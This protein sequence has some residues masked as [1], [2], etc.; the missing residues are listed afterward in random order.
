MRSLFLG[1]LTGLI[2]QTGA[3]QAEYSINVRGTDYPLAALMESC[4]N[5]N[6]GPEAQLR[7]FVA[8]TGLVKEQTAAPET[9]DLS[10]TEAL[11]GLRA[12]AEYQDDIS[13][14]SIS[15]TDCTI[16]VQYHG[17]YFYV[18]RRNVTSIDLLSATFDVSQMQHDQTA[19]SQG[20]AVQHARGI[21]QLGA[22]ASTRG[23]LA[24]ESAEHGFMSKTASASVSEYAS[25]IIQNLPERQDRSFDFVLVHPAKIQSS[26]QIWGAFGA[27]VGA[28]QKVS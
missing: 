20:T 2:V 19:F 16:T 17:D 11:D 1:A 27:L 6:G 24:L 18:S 14:L 25:S 5:A 4:I 10:V 23:G 9:T 8:L 21:M 13:G 28:C 3:A 22:T 26:N 15:G 12:V 7:C